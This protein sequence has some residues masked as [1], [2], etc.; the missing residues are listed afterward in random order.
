MQVAH[1]GH[2]EVRPR[3]GLRP[4]VLG[5][6][7]GLLVSCGGSPPPPPTAGTT[8]DATSS[9]SLVPSD[10]STSTAADTTA[11]P[12]TGELDDGGWCG[13]CPDAG[14]GAVEPPMLVRHALECPPCGNPVAFECDVVE[15][16]C[17]VQERCM[18]WANDGGA[19]WNATRCSPIDP[20]AAGPGEPCIAIGSALSG[21][22]SCGLGS[23]CWN[24]D[25]TTLEGE[26]VAMCSA[27]PAM[28][29]VCD[30]PGARCAVYNDGAIALCLPDCDPLAP[31]CAG[32][33]RCVPTQAGA[34]VC[35]PGLARPSNAEC[36]FVNVCAPGSACLVAGA[37]ARCVGSSGCCTSICDVTAMD[38]CVDP[39][40]CVHPFAPGEAPP[41]RENA[42]VCA[43]APRPPADGWWPH[44]SLVARQ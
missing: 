19:A 38:S 5:L 6:G 20:R 41:E 4:R 30:D 8:G 26:C 43:S 33:H 18:P 42:G 36:E 35:V 11:G 31:S 2:D 23:M 27:G 16:R 37:G 13:I 15:Q 22:D 3:G 7:L 17:P 32:D 9:T 21:L 44:W 39:Q 25:P 28:T 24:V 40:S 29:L 10:G 1:T 14:A 12:D 34:W